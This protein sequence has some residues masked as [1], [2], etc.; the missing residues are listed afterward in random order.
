W[1]VTTD[2]PPAAA[3]KASKSGPNART[4]PLSAALSDLVPVRTSE[5]IL[6]VGHNL[7]FDLLV[8]QWNGVTVRGPFFDTMIAHA[9]VEPELRHG[10][11]YLSEA[12]LGYTPIPLERLIGAKGAEQRTLRDVPMAEITEY[13]AEDADVT[14]QLHERL[15]PLLAERGQERVFHDVEMPLLPAL[16]AMEF[17]G[18]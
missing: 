18:V 14:W 16:V 10:M 8:L 13:A 15:A 2:D 3:A 11:D 12:L 6:K 9:L 17:E 5:R 7:K 1:Y 4:H